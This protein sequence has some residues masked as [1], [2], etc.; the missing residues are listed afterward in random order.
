MLRLTRSS[1]LEV[2]ALSSFKRLQGTGAETEITTLT[3]GEQTISTLF[4]I[5][6]K[7]NNKYIKINICNL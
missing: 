7:Y 3:E 1:R 6:Y 5:I 2:E 4:L